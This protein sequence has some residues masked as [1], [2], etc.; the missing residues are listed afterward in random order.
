[1]GDDAFVITPFGQDRRYLELQDLVLIDQGRAERGK[2]PSRA[3]LLQQMQSKLD[4][5]TPRP[6]IYWRL[7]AAA[8]WSL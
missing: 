2:L 6:E 1:V 5:N 7:Q 8:D 4:L 3:V